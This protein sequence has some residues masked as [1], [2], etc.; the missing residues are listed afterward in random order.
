MKLS[1]QICCL[2]VLPLLL[3]CGAIIGVM[4]YFLNQSIYGWNNDAVDFL[5][6]N[7]IPTESLKHAENVAFDELKYSII[8][9]GGFVGLVVLCAVRSTYRFANRK[10]HEINALSSKMGKSTTRFG[11]PEM[12]E[13]KTTFLESQQLDKSCRQFVLAVRYTLGYYDKTNF[14][15][16]LKI[17]F[18]TEKLMKDVRN[19]N[20]LGFV[21]QNIGVYFSQLA[22]IE[23]NLEK[24][25]TYLKRS[26]KTAS[27]QLHSVIE[28]QAENKI[29]LDQ[30]Q[31]AIFIIMGDRWNE[32]AMLYQKTDNQEKSLKAYD[33]AIENYDSG[34]DHLGKVKVSGSKGLYLIE[35]K[36]YESAE[37]LLRESI[38]HMVHM[39][40]QNSEKLGQ[41]EQ[42]SSDY[43]YYYDKYCNMIEPVQYGSVYYGMYL[44]H[45]DELKKASNY[46]IYALKIH[47]QI[48][49]K[50]YY[51]CLRNL[52][53]SLDGLK[54]PLAKFIKNQMIP[55][56]E[57]FFVLDTSA[58]M[59]CYKT[60]YDLDTRKPKIDPENGR[61]IR[62]PVL[63]QC[64][65]CMCDM[66]T[67]YVYPHDFIN[68]LSFDDRIN[69]M[70]NQ[71]IPTTETN[72]E[73]ILNHINNINLGRGTSF[74]NAVFTAL[75]KM[76]FNK[77]KDQY[78]VVFT[79]GADEHSHL[80]TPY[81]SVE[82]I[83]Q[84]IEAE[85]KGI[86]VIIITYSEMDDQYAS[87]IHQL[88]GF[89]K[90]SRHIRISPEHGLGGIEDAFIQCANIINNLE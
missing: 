65:D 10:T 70:S 89:T 15:S 12:G 9:L 42:G 27:E 11:D 16:T 86:H 59:G 73:A 20:G 82:K 56:K 36:Q 63:Q 18:E 34:S 19:I 45:M 87:K 77:D 78:I 26:I 88:C 68:M 25:E 46:F 40:D 8:A 66:I 43:K 13:V 54:H 64:K 55:S 60:I 2:I 67:K 75:D 14:V 39:M 71:M 4:V 83:I 49:T 51:L 35:L 1:N 52:W 62:K 47:N 81:A 29:N 24:A 50:L 48:D 80:S 21:Q 53:G 69:V 30:E 33:R 37:K 90:K 61:P 23:N 76:I 6:S 84:L 38:E 32:L 44:K 57:L 58:S 72:I 3:G 5:R 31:C 41:C 22:Q 7:N 85:K 79:D 28:Q 17:M 74:Y